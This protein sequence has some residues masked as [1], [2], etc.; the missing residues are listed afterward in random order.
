MQIWALRTLA[1]SCAPDV[2]MAHGYARNTCSQA[3]APERLAALRRCWRRW[4]HNSASAAC[5]L[6]GKRAQ[7]TRRLSEAVRAASAGVSEG[8]AP[9][10]FRLDLG[11]PEER[12]TAIPDGILAG[13]ACRR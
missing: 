8:V 3:V 13:S 12:T 4:S 6:P 9:D 2:M 1:G 11:M 7:A 5:T 10:G